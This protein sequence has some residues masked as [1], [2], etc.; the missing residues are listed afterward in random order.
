[1]MQGGGTVLLD[2][3]SDWLAP[4]GATAYL[5]PQT[6]ESLLVFHAL[7]SSENGAMYLWLKHISWQDDWPVLTD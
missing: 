4:G 3:N 6:G 1:M 5:D 7:K 2:S